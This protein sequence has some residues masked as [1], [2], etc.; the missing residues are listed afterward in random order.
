MVCKIYKALPFWSTYFWTLQ[1]FSTASIHHNI[2]NL[3]YE[4]PYEVPN[5]LRLRIWWYQEILKKSQICVGGNQKVCKSWY[6][7]FLALPNFIRFLYFVSNIFSAFVWTDKSVMINW[8]SLLQI[9]EFFFTFSI[10]SKL[11]SE[12]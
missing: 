1:Y 11:F 6:Q 12:L 8:P 3:V 5:N 10:N 9:S 2:R 7:S 4:L